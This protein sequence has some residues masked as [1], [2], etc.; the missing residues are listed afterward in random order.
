MTVKS[1]ESSRR[2]PKGD[3]RDRTR[4]RLL[5]AARAIVREK[6]YARTTLEAVALRA[7]MTTGAIYGN[8]KNRD[9]L[10]IALGQAYWPPVAPRLKPGATFAEAMHAMAE[11]TLAAIPERTT[12][13]VGRLTGL[14]YALTSPNLRERVREVTAESYEFGAEW[15]RTLGDE[16]ELPMPPEHLVRVIH[17]LIEG[18]VLQR[19]LTP[20]LCPDEVFFAAFDALAHRRREPGLGPP[21]DMILR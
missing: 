6:G 8:F 20:E 13:A 16:R 11:A 7:G 12:V 14:A 10:F 17:A 4:A 19:I 9:E 1:A 5:E 15:L 3:K 18:L 2:K 21:D